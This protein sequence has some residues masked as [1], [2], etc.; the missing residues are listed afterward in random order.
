MI[1]TWVAIRV[2][3]VRASSAW[4]RRL[5]GC[6]SDMEQDHPHREHFDQISADD[7]TVLLNLVSWHD[8]DQPWSAQSE[9]GKGLVLD[10]VLDDFDAAWQRARA[11]GAD[12]LRQPQ[13]GTS[14]Y[15]THEFSLRDPDGYVVS[16]LDATTGW[17]K[18]QLAQVRR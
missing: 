14:G 3:D 11:L 8:H 18:T 9:T 1:R 2:A 7:G 15:R 12:V 5:L 10:F 6:G 4:Y 16:V 17:P 13:L